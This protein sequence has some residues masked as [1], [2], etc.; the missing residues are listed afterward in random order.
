[1]K[2]ADGVAGKAIEEEGRGLVLIATAQ[3]DQKERVQECVNLIAFMIRLT[4]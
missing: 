4:L 2:L 1:M 3:S